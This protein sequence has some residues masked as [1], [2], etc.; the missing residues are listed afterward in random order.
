MGSREVVESITQLIRD[1]RVIGISTLRHYP[2]EKRIYNR[3]GRCGFAIEVVMGEKGTKRAYAVLVEAKARSS[4]I[5]RSM[6]YDDEPGEIECLIAEISREGVRYTTLKGAY[7]NSAE[8]F[9]YVEKVR[10]AFYEKYRAL[11]V[12]KE[13]VEKLISEEVFH[14]AGVDASD[15]FLGT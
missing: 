13:E 10:S 9:G 4:G 14:S 6:T 15:L 2:M 7:S 12:S 5:D 1:P 11:K 3:F 8:L